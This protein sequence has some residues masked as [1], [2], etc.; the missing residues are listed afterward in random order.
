MA[1]QLDEGRAIARRKMR[2][3]GLTAAQ[4]ARKARQ[5]QILGS[6]TA[7]GGDQRDG[8]T[9][10]TL[11]YDGGNVWGEVVVSGGSGTYQ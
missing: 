5:L 11:G 1:T 2:E 6:R 7:G 3:Q 9:V 4:A 8:P 10:L